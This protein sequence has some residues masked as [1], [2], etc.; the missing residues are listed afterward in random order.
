MINGLA[1]AQE[2]LTHETY[3]FSR[4]FLGRQYHI[5]D[6]SDLCSGIVRKIFKEIHQLYAFIE[7]LSPLGMGAMKFTITRLFTLRM[8]HTKFGQILLEN[9]I[10]T[11]DE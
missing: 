2:P 10:L 5:L 3:N 6:L 9:R 11:D 8:L 7:K 4:A 1:L